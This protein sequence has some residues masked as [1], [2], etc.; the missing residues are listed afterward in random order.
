[1]HG[2]V[3]EAALAAGMLTRDC[4]GGQLIFPEVIMSRPQMGVNAMAK[5]EVK[6]T[7]TL[8]DLGSWF[9]VCLQCHHALPPLETTG[10]QYFA[11]GTVECIG[12]RARVDLWEC[13]RS[14]IDNDF[15]PE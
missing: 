5:D 14:R 11:E 8:G 13:V 12:C 1:V 10:P 2:T 9:G 4:P 3:H 6:S 7:V 15:P